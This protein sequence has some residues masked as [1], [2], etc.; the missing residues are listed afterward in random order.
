MTRAERRIAIRLAAYQAF[1]EHGYHGTTV[2]NICEIAEISKGSFY[3]YFK[4]KQAV[5]AHIVEAWADEV[6]GEM[7]NQF[8]EA[9]T[10]NQ[11]YAAIALALIREAKRSRKIIPVWIEFLAEA[12]RE[13]Y[14]REVLG[15]FHARLRNVLTELL[16]LAVDDNV[17]EPEVAA[18]ASVALASFFGLLCQEL[19]DP[20][21]AG[22]QTHMTAFMKLIAREVVAARS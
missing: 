1:S 18:L 3:W 16:E 22:F 14:A 13:E 10:A 11:P 15:K 8:R 2:D 6:A 19:T 4:S 9:M 12:S 21:F 20:E 5:F 7:A 17:S